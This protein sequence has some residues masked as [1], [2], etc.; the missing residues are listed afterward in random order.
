MMAMTQTPSSQERMKNPPPFLL[1]VSS[2]PGTLVMLPS[3][4]R[5]QKALALFL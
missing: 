3:I 1:G 2:S 5:T 4:F